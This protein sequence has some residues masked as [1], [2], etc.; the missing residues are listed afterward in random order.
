[1][2]F[3]IIGIGV[4]VTAVSALT[5]TAT[6]ADETGFASSHDWRKERGMTC[7]VDHYHYGSSGQQRTKALAQREAIVS[8]QS[9]TSFE[10]G[11]NWA[12]YAKA[13]SKKMTCSD[14]GGSWE[15]S[16]EARPCR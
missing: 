11:S 16:V 15:C 3:S 2:R 5:P 4:A 8:W 10:Y 1:M 13:G 12:R 9:F 7:M 14:A 6:R